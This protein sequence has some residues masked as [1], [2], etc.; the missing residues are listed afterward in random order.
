MRFTVDYE[1]NH[2]NSFDDVFDCLLQTQ[3]MKLAVYD[4]YD[5]K[6][7]NSNDSDCY[8]P[9]RSHSMTQL[10]ANPLLPA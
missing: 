6:Y 2:M 9:I 4:S 7:K 5:E 8:N 1:C 10:S 3:L